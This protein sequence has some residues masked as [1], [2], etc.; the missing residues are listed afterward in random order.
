MRGVVAELSDA[1]SGLTQS[2]TANSLGEARF[3]AIPPS[4]Y[5]LT[6]TAAGFA[7][8]TEKITVAIGSRPTVR[9]TLL[10]TR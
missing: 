3:E 5:S 7:A 1:G 2:V 9:V 4:T 6:V 8:Q 10:G